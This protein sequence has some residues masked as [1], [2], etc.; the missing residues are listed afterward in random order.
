MHSYIHKYT[1]IS[2]WVERKHRRALQKLTEKTQ[3]LFI[4][5][6]CLK[7][8]FECACMF[9]LVTDALKLLRHPY[10]CVYVCIYFLRFQTSLELLFAVSQVSG[11]PPVSQPGR[12][13]ARPSASSPSNGIDLFTAELRAGRQTSCGSFIQFLL[14]CLV[15]VFCRKLSSSGRRAW[16]QRIIYTFLN[17]FQDYS[18]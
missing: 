7:S 2:G 13:S 3:F 1:W 15:K 6:I 5:F 11:A 9:V 12:P 10:L 18:I 17:I 16:M 8:I 4:E 14:L